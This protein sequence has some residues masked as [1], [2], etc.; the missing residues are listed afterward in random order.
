MIGKFKNQK[1]WMIF[2]LSKLLIFGFSESIYA[3]SFNSYSQEE[4]LPGNLIYFINQDYKGWIWA[5]TD[6]GLSRFDGYRF[7]NFKPSSKDTNS[8]KGLGVRT[9]FEDHRKNLWIGTENGGLNLFNREL[10]TF[11]QPFDSIPLLSSNQST[12]FDI[13]EDET[14]NLWV[15]TGKNIFIIDSLNKVTM[16]W[17]GDPSD[18]NNSSSLSIFKIKL[19]KSGNLW[20]G[21]RTYLY[22]VDVKSNKTTRLDLM[23]NNGGFYDI[24]DLYLDSSNLMWVATDLNGLFVIDPITFKVTQIVC[25]PEK[26]RSLSIRQVTED[27]KG[28]YW[29]TTRSGLYI[30]DPK[31]RTMKYFCHDE[32]EPH[33]LLNNSV[34]SVFCDQ[35]G[36]MWVGTRQ[37]ISLLIQSKQVFHNFG[38]HPTDKTNR[39][40]NSKSVYALW[41]DD[42]ENIWVGTEDGGINIYNKHTQLYHYL[43]KEKDNPNSVSENC[44]KAFLDDKKG[45]LWVGSFHGGIDVINIKRRK[46]YHFKNDPNNA[47]S[48]G[49]NDVWDF[50]LDNEGKIWIATSAGVDQY[51]PATRQFTQF[52]NLTVKE[53]IN[54]I[55]KDTNNNIWLGSGNEVVIYT[56]H[57]GDIIRHK[58]HSY[59]FLEDS[60]GRFWITTIDAGLAQY[61]IKD[62]P[63][64]YFNKEEGL[65]CTQTFCILEDNDRKL[66]IS[67]SNGLSRFDPENNSFLNFHKKDGILNNVFC[68]GAAYKNSRGELL[69]GS[70][71]GFIK[72]DP[73][74]ITTN[75][76]PSPIVLTELRVQNRKVEFGNNNILDKSIS[77]TKQFELN[78]PQNAFMLE[79][80]ALNYRAESNKY[81]YYLEGLENE[82]SEPSNDRVAA[83][84][85]LDPGNYI[86]HICSVENNERLIDATLK[87]SIIIRPPFWKT[88]WFKILL[89]VFLILLINFIIQF[90]I[91]RERTKM[92][93]ELERVK[94]NKQNELNNLKLKFFTNISHE[95]RTPLTLI[96]TPL[97]KLRSKKLRPNEIE[98]YVN[99]IYRNTQNLNNLI[100]QLLDFRKLENG[101]MKLELAT[102]DLVL[103]ISE[104]VNS[105]QNLANEKGIY[106]KF[107]TFQNKL[108]VIFDADF[109]RKILNNLLSN[110]FKF[111]QKE[112]KITV[113]LTL[114]F[115]YESDEINQN[116][117]DKVF[118][119]ISVSDT[120]IGIPKKNLKKIFDRFFQS[121]TSADQTGTGIGLSFAK[122]LVKLHE[123]EIF[124]ESKTGKGSKFTFRIPYLTEQSI[125]T[126]IEYIEPVKNVRSINDD[127]TA[128]YE[129]RQIML[130]VEDNPDLRMLI[131]DHFRE[132][133]QVYEAENGIDGWQLTLKFIPDVIISDVLMPDV[134]GFE[135]CKK[136]KDDERTSHIPFLLLTALHAKENIIKGLESGAD[137]YITKPFDIMILETKI[138]N[139][140]SIRN[141]YKE[142]YS[143]VMSL[144]PKNIMIDSPDQKFLQKTISVIEVHIS[145]PELDLGTFVSEVG[146]SR[147]QLYRKLHALTDMT[148]MEFIRD[149]R[150]KRAAQLLQQGTMTI[151][152]I[153]YAVGFKDVS[154]FGKCFRNEYKKTAK[155]YQK[156]IMSK[157][158]STENDNN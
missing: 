131:K 93:L 77:E 109:I 92:E 66:W 82:W 56:P 27:Q 28:N 124:V 78:Y 31:M 30:Y 6:H 48:I 97:E 141:S 23:T 132:I 135:F 42:K 105:Y 21:T 38:A 61:T 53:R 75:D 44:I 63:V 34:T 145:D 98:P 43:K 24:V 19:D 17:S 81:S 144:Q 134:D 136:V 94:A 59:S 138:E 52:P 36:E 62:G 123:G 8:I 3:L 146:V 11:T 73:A 149:I 156:S 128:N 45:N 10:E 25:T 155:E 108:D 127:E 158:V 83:Y 148:V 113:S 126:N 151:S 122:E 50:T 16:F 12:V 70:I 121:E 2:L 32:R 71:N 85:N 140:L 29:I 35:R 86:L 90:F 115:N 74:E 64:R 39:Y 1:F 150:L 99:I 9:I 5:G 142:K 88:K 47:N 101:N 96:L 20:I 129:N 143:E 22:L 102:G 26:E 65:P 104:V 37:G 18:Q 107:H 80:A 54:W 147:M 153:A 89:F 55:E 114:V 72:F 15:A 49:S 157:R 33:S 139:I 100:N 111:T 91:F 119:E 106:L 69:Y 67:T 79:F 46:I 40:L 120:G 137:D 118:V 51:D 154:H 76:M 133:F 110:A 57:T 117:S 60:K 13:E 116:Q 41:V 14:G 7:R 95:I 87:I 130:I 84:N 152:E 58:E 112:G 68:Y 125:I 4:G 103:C